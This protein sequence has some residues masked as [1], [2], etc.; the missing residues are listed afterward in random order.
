VSCASCAGRSLVRSS[1][2]SGTW[3]RWA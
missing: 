1:T 2:R 3:P